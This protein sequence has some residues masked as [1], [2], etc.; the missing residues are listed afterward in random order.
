MLLPLVSYASATNTNQIPM[1]P[2][3]QET[4][5]RTIS[6]STTRQRHPLAFLILETV[7]DLVAQEDLLMLYESTRRQKKDFCHL[8]PFVTSFSSARRVS[9]IVAST[10]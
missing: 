8:A 10:T 1:R 2:H 5:H 4:I 9:V 3:A 6:R 7:T